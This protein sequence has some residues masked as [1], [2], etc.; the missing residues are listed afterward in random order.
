MCKIPVVLWIANAA[1]CFSGR[2]GA[3]TRQAQQHQLSRQTVYNNA[4]QVQ[5][6]IQV[7]HSCDSLTR[8]AASR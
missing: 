2:H 4:H 1:A 7:E 6:A 5:E 3:V 8:A